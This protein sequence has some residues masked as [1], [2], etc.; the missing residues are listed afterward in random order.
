M[1]WTIR[2]VIAFHQPVIVSTDLATAIAGA[3]CPATYYGGSVGDWDLT[4]VKHYPGND[5]QAADHAMSDGI[6]YALHHVARVPI[7]LGARFLRV[8][9]VRSGFPFGTRLPHID[10]REAHVLAAGYAMY[11]ILLALAL[12]G[13]L[14]LR[15][16]REAAWILVAPFLLVS[17]VAVLFYGTPRLRQPA[18][19]AIVVLSALALEHDLSRWRSRPSNREPRPETETNLAPASRTSSSSSA[20]NGF[21]D[22]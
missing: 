13:L 11:L 14:L 7:V 19:V 16:R 18:E 12:Q 5:A 9:G 17:L 15:R 1:P 3:N 8:W 10:G 20:A 22:S 2:N 6:R 21:A 4:C